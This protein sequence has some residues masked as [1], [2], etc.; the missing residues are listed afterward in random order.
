VEIERNRSKTEYS[1]KSLGL[2]KGKRENEANRN[3]QRRDAEE[4]DGGFVSW[5][6]VVRMEKNLPK[7]KNKGLR[8]TGRPGGHGRQTYL[9]GGQE[10][11]KEDAKKINL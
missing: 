8:Q 7:E 6:K 2:M 4:E 10:H 5:K 11:G 9:G 3:A 1:A